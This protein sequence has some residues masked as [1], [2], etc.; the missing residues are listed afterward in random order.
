MAIMRGAVKW[1]LFLAFVSTSVTPHG[2]AE[3][4]DPKPWYKDEYFDVNLDTVIAERTGERDRN[5]DWLRGIRIGFGGW[6]GPASDQVG[7]FNW[8]GRYA[9]GEEQHI[10]G[11][12]TT[13]SFTPANLGP[14]RFSVP[15]SHGL[16]YRTE[17]PHAGID[18]H[19]GIGGEVGVW[20]APYVQLAASATRIFAMPSGTRDHVSYKL[21]VGWKKGEHR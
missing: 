10:Y 7:W 4:T 11:L 16:E 19:L 12:G 15:L 21:I 3:A 2:A 8:W 13:L 1:T 9:V 17:G 14:L 20:I 18:A 6:D 5:G